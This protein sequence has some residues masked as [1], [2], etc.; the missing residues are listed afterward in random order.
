MHATSLRSLL[1][2]LALLVT[3]PLSANDFEV[4]LGFGSGSP[5]QKNLFVRQNPVFL[6]T[7]FNGPWTLAGL[8]GAFEVFRGEST[9]LW[10]TAGYG[11][12]LG[13]PAYY[14][15]GSSGYSYD[16]LDGKVSYASFSGGLRVSF[17]TP[18]LGEYGIELAWRQHGVTYSGS[19]TQSSGAAPVRQDV[20]IKST[21]SDLFLNL[22][23]GIAQKH[24]TFST[25]QRVGLGLS[26]G[27]KAGDV[28]AGDW[29]FGPKYLERV[30][31]ATEL[32]LAFGIRL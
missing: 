12:S 23:A 1:P 20:S 31:P 9:K 10:V 18:H 32:T 14:Q 4:G 13:S 15:D 21:S 3:A 26:L 11:T 22:S 17:Q 7:R 8:N 16:A 28:A 27:S 29:N 30:R 2:V 5:T 6:E 19:R 24:P 25:F